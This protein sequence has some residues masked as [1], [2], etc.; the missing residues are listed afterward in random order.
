M[1][2]AVDFSVLYWALSTGHWALSTSPLLGARSQQLGAPTAHCSKPAAGGW[3][4]VA[5]SSHKPQ[6]TTCASI[7]LTPSHHS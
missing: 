4:L 2:Y 3:R 5:P 6:A 7:R 1:L